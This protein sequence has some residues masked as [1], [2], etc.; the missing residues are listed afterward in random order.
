M[1]ALCGCG[2]TS[3]EQRERSVIE[4]TD[5]IVQQHG[6][7]TFNYKKENVLQSVKST[8]AIQG[9]EIAF[10]KADGSLLI[11]KPLRMGEQNQIVSPIFYAP[12]NSY[13]MLRQYE[14][15]LE[16]I[17]GK[18]KVSMKPNV[19]VGLMI[20]I[21]RT[22]IYLDGPTG[23]IELWNRFFARVESLLK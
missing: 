18:V 15:R 4:L 9:Y 2:T 11:T 17:E 12:Y 16:T 10:E 19:S 3:K 5:E 6:T 13:P 23:E 14:V 20:A 8:L 22:K 21:E 1:I 7:R